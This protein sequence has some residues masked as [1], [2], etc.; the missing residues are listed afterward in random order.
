MVPKDLQDLEPHANIYEDPQ[1]K[2]NGVFDMIWLSA[3]WIAWHT[4]D[5]VEGVLDYVACNCYGTLHELWWSVCISTVRL[6]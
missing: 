2:L 4:T 3:Y 5:M 6:H 1:A